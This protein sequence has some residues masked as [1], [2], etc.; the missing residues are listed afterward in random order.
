MGGDGGVIAVKRKFIKE[1]KT[2]EKRQYQDV[3]DTQFVRASTCAISGSP[4]QDPIVC[5]RL[6]YL[7][8]KEAI[9]T[10]ILD[11]RLDKAF[12]HIRKLKGIKTLQFTPNPEYQEKS[13]GTAVAKYICP[14]T[15]T[16]FDGVHPFV[17]IWS[18][19]YVI[20]EKALREIGI[21]GLQ[22]E[23]GPFSEN[24][25]VRLL[26]SEEELN[27]RRATLEAQKELSAR[28]NE[29]KKRSREP[30]GEGDPEA[31]KEAGKKHQRS[32]DH[33]IVSAPKSV[34]NVAKSHINENEGKSEV[35]K[36]LFHKDDDKKSS[37]RDLFMSV[38]GFRYTLS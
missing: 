10:A 35:Y 31:L 7:F 8:N 24:D 16:A 25:I 13:N 3:K 17:A 19:G 9:L 29:G 28:K 2:E 18:T 21:P 23:Y 11:K 12:S 37:D 15:M 30:Q 26:P 38:A 6:G 32:K 1:C 4:L 36:K 5:C 14:V 33:A 34:V 22:T 20:S 27:T